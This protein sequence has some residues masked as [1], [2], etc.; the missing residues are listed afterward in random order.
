M[1]FIID[2]ES[3]FFRHAECIFI[4][5]VKVEAPTSSF[6]D[7]SE[8]HKDWI[9]Q[10]IDAT[11]KTQIYNLLS[12]EKGGEYALDWFKDGKGYFLA[13]CTWVPFVAPEK[14]FILY[15][16]WEQSNLIGNEVL[17]EK[18]EDSKAIIKIKP[19]YFEVYKRAG[20]LKQQIAF[21]DYKSIFNT[22]WHDRAVKAGWKLDISY[23]EEECIL[24][25]Y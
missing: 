19:L 16:C 6:P 3:W 7:I 9:R 14:A 10:E 25:F 21:E 8:E 11:N 23:L 18:L 4:R 24:Q 20:H 22:I 17:L 12:V 2:N 13:A 1:S 15:L 5:L